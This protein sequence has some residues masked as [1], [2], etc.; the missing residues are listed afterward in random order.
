VSQAELV[1]IDEAAAIPI[2]LVKQLIG[3]YLVILSSTI[4]GYEGTGR[5]L[6][7]KL[8]SSLKKQNQI[9]RNRDYSEFGGDRY[10]K[11]IQLDEPIRYGVND[12]LE[13]WL[14]NLLCLQA[15]SEVPELKQGF[16]HPNEC[17]LYFVNRDTLF[18]YHSATEKFLTKIMSIFVSSHYKNT[19][20]DL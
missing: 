3:P 11:E 15:T 10:L 20:N 19:P 14:N 5:S 2:T 17:D 18:S 8:I 13:S 4:H 6:S 7:L 12:P 1:V 16:P 9:G